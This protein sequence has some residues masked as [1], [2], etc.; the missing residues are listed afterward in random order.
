MMSALQAYQ[1][2]FTAHLRHPQTHSKPA[3]IPAKRMAIYRE[4]VF[5][6]LL[7]SMR[8]CF[9]VLEQIVGKRL[10][11][12]LV[13][14]CFQQQHFDSPLFREIPQFFVQWLQQSDLHTLGLPPFAAQLAH[15]EWVELYLA[16]LD[17]ENPANTQAT[18]A[19][20]NMMLTLH[21]AHLLLAYDYPV[22][23]LSKRFQ[24]TETIA[25]FLCL[26]RRADFSIE[27]IQLNAISWQ[28]LKLLE[29]TPMTAAQ[30]LSTLATQLQYPQ[31]ETLQ[32]FGNRLLLDL[33][34]KQLLY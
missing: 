25:T 7:G 22:H 9:P 20:P 17:V 33:Y 3:G 14:Q 29:E 18:D 12:R 1:T 10:F 30:A 8:T 11:K 28:L 5:N 16:N 31:P 6:N 32:T 4:I 15:Y 2:A 24:P 27:F 13:R 19:D 23:Q 34:Q 26:Y 21:P